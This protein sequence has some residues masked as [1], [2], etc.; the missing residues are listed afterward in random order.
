LR[1]SGGYQLAEFAFCCDVYHDSVGVAHDQDFDMLSIDL[2]CRLF[3]PYYRCCGLYPYSARY[4][5]IHSVREQE[6]QG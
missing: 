6:V 4:I 1:N 2:L 5:A 3:G